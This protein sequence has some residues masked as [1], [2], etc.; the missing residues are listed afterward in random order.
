MI[1]WVFLGL[2]R[3]CPGTTYTAGIVVYEST[4]NGIMAACAASNKTDLNVILISTTSH[5]GGMVTGGLS[6]TDTVNKSIIGGA[7]DQ[8]FVMNGKYY[9]KSYEFD[10]EPH[11]VTQIFYDLLNTTNVTLIIDSPIQSADIDTDNKQILSIT[12][13]NGNIYKSKLFMDASYEGDLMA[14]VNVSWT[15]GRESVSKYNESYAGRQK[16][17][18]GKDNFKYYINPYTQNRSYSL[19][20]MITEFDGELLGSGDDKVESYNYRLCLT[21][22]SKYRISFCAS[23]PSNYDPDNWELLR[24]VYLNSPPTIH[25]IPS[26]RTYRIPSNSTEYQKYDMNTCGAVS[27]DY[28][29]E[30]D[31]YIYLNYSQRLQRN[32]KHREY[33]MELLWFMC[34]DQSVPENIRNVMV[35]KWGFCGDEFL[36]NDI[37]GFPPQLYIREARRLIGDRV[38][39]QMMALRDDNYLGLESIGVGS[40]SFDS[41]NTQ[42]Y[43]CK[44]DSVCYAAPEKNDNDLN[45]TAYV[46]NEGNIIHPKTP[47]TYQIPYWILLPKKEEMNNLLVSCAVSTSHVGITSIRVEATWMIIGQSAGIYGSLAV[48]KANENVNVHNVSL[49]ELNKILLEQ[50]QILTT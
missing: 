14:A 5:I 9:N 11:I 35:N 45:S 10:F 38:F 31:D 32:M 37:P 1:S 18:V 4:P 30:S 6:K 42:R 24:G 26:C 47:K 13:I 19:L 20:P 33:T 25:D 12:T 8:I 28:L 36:E 2:V 46:I 3:L 39:T 22:T 7:T 29:G 34:T 43:A 21:N 27:T 41:H 17:E 49:T 48:Q 23:K 15:I 50:E 44:N 16:P 40:Y